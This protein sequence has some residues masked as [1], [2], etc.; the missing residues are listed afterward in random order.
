M[1]KNQKKFPWDDL[2]P[3]EEKELRHAIAIMCRGQVVPEA[4][5]NR[6]NDRYLFNNIRS[7]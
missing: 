2:T 7:L 1:S 3:Q 4:S 5:G 6:F